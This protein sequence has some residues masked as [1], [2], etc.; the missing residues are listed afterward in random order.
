LES[1]VSDRGL[2]FVAEIIKELNNML[3][4]ETKLS[5]SFHPQTD[6]QTERMN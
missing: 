1:I 3:G 6:G 4:I 2:Q 5:T